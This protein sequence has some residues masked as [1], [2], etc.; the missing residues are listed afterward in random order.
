MPIFKGFRVNRGA[1]GA[2]AGRG[3]SPYSHIKAPVPPPRG[4]ATN[5]AFPQY[6]SMVSV[7][8]YSGAQTIG[9]KPPAQ[10]VGLS[11]NKAA[12][13]A[14]SP[15]AKAKALKAINKNPLKPSSGFASDAGFER[16][17]EAVDYDSARISESSLKR[18]NYR[19][20]PQN[21]ITGKAGRT[22]TEQRD[23]DEDTVGSYLAT[24]KNKYSTEGQ[25]WMKENS[26]DTRRKRYG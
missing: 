5:P 4:Q 22:A 11:D 19:D 7:N 26:A 24:G 25:K 12:R 6:R 2:G 8:P 21:P 16:S 15:K 1:S 17:Q 20:M 14:N 10:S 9:E 18:N 3:D 23:D 13:K